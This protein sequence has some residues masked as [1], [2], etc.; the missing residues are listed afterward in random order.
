MDG[1][2]LVVDGEVVLRPITAAHE[3]ALVAAVGSS[4]AALATWMPWAS[5]DYGTT[6][7]RVFLELVAAGAEHAYAITTV[8]DDA[9]HG[10]CGVNRLDPLNRTANVGYWLA[11][12]STGRGLATRGVRR[13]LVHALEA[14]D[15]ERLE[16]V[17]A[18]DNRPSVAV[19][20]RLELHDEGVRR[21]ALRVGD[22]QHDARVFAAFPTDLDR[23]RR[24]PGAA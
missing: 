4:H 15:L 3:G 9:F 12:A 17:A 11:T 18:V 21:R 8:A 19:A 22:T 20:Q 2:T 13:L 14:L 24:R 7:A 6:E 5:A 10:V 1:A 23:L 16:I